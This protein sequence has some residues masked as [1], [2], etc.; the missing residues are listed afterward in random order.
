MHETARAIDGREM[1]LMKVITESI[2]FIAE[3]AM[4]KLQE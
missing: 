3:K 1:S 2:R 4:E